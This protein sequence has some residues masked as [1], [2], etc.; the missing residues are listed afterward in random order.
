MDPLERALPHRRRPLLSSRMA[1][2]GLP[3]SDTLA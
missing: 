2:L 1:G 3:G